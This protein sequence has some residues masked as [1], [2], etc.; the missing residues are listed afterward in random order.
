MSIDDCTTGSPMFQQLS[1]ISLQSWPHERLAGLYASIVMYEKNHKL[2]PDDIRNK[3][4]LRERLIAMD[5]PEKI[6][7][8]RHLKPGEIRD[9]YKQHILVPSTQN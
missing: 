1:D 4:K 3:G 7:T 5:L 6:R 2:H 9:I 8:Y